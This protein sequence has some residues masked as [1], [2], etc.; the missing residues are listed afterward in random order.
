[1]I[2]LDPAKYILGQDKAAMQWL[3]EQIRE[4]SRFTK[5]ATT[6]CIA[7]KSRAVVVYDFWRPG[8]Q[9]LGIAIAGEPGWATKDKIKTI[10]AVP[11]TMLPVNRLHSIVHKKNKSARRLNEGAGF[12]LE[13]T[14]KDF[15]G[16]GRGDAC[17]YRLLRQEWE[18]GRFHYDF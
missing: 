8:H 11:F 6:L 3:A 14:H 9:T 13:G 1:M 18:K 16:P 17:T 15:W 12:V 10:L 4:P 2:E 7:G 5:Q